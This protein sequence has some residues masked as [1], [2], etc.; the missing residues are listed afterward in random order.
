MECAPTAMMGVAWVGSLRPGRESWSGNELGGWRLPAS[1]VAQVLCAGRCLGQGVGQLEGL[2]LSASS[3]WLWHLRA[4]SRGPGHHAP[5]AV[6]LCLG[7][8]RPLLRPQWGGAVKDPGA[9]SAAVHG[10]AGLD[11]TEGLD[12]DSSKSVTAL[13]HVTLGS[14]SG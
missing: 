8:Q 12:S 2:G 13:T 7:L 4:G 5:A 14:L 3:P 9:R 6:V 1:G 11:T 10:V